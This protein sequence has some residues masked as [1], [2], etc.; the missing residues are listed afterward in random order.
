VYRRPTVSR[1]TATR[2]T[3]S[4][5]RGTPRHRY[6]P[7]C[8]AR[9]P[10]VTATRVLE[11]APE[12]RR[13][14]TR[15]AADDDPSTDV[16]ATHGPARVRSPALGARVTAT[17]SRRRPPVA[18]RHRYART[19]SRTRRPTTRGS[20]LRA[21]LNSVRPPGDTATRARTGRSTTT[22]TGG[23]RYARTHS[24]TRRPTTR[25][26]PLRAELN[27]VRPPG[28]T[29]TRGPAPAHGAFDDDDDDRGSPLRADFAAVRW[30]GVTAT[31][32]T[33]FAGCETRDYLNM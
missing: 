28:D 19:H 10:S 7:T 1:V 33:H 16:T 12:A 8:T 26:S 29:A 17:H 30:S 27:S 14:R 22:T 24:R 5:L 3:T 6:A 18:G 23:H 20:P 21:E 32:G 9:G 31:R 13:P 2:H 4:P 25:G 11:A 15:P